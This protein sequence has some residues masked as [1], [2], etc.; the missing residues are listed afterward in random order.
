KLIHPALLQRPLGLTTHYVYPQAYI[1]PGVVLPTQLQSLSSPYIDYS[2]S[3]AYAQYT[4]PAF[5]Q[6][7]Y[8]ASPAAGYIG[9]GYSALQQPITAGTSATA[10]STTLLQ[11]Q[12]QQLQPDR[13][14]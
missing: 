6:Y 4:A 2:T 14:Q 11:Y 1:Q 12:A 7:P 13:V 8:A 3:A 10:G 5:D 9:Y